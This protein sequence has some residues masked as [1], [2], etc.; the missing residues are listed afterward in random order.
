MFNLSFGGRCT[1][2]SL[3]VKDLAKTFEKQQPSK[4]AKLDAL[5][6]G[7]DAGWLR[8]ISS[9]RNYLRRSREWAHRQHWR[10][11]DWKW[12]YFIHAYH[13]EFKEWGKR[14]PGIS[15]HAKY[16]MYLKRL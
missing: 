10:N 8:Q 2:I 4:I 1:S 9:A 5:A 14:R 6:P 16:D 15:L 13:I 11:S 3:G 7:Q 12:R